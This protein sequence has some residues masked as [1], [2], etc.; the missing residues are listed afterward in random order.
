[1]PLTE[2]YLS[3]FVATPNVAVMEAPASV[4]SVS[5]AEAC[6]KLC[7][8]GYSASFTCQKFVLSGTSCSL[9]SGLISMTP[10]YGVVWGQSGSTLYSLLS[11]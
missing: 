5:G 11:K 10:A 2:S 1:M 7:L 9:Y 3:N 8:T 4:S 6:A